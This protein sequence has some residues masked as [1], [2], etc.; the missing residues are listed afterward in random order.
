MSI[1]K[2]II[3]ATQQQVVNLGFPVM[4]PLSGRIKPLEEHPEVIFSTGALG[5]GL[6]LEISSHKI[7]APFDGIIEKVKM[8]GTEVY[9]K[10][11]NGLR[12]LVALNID[13]S[14]F[15]LPGLAIIKH[16]NQNVKASEAIVHF[17]LRKVP[18]P[19]IASVTILNYQKLGAIYYSHNQITAGEDVLFKVT[20]KKR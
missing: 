13:P 6:A 20:A 17:D 1:H 18:T 8:G 7:I 4:S 19:I 14:Y 9:F 12:L 2:Q 5:C 10:A 15:P 3:F 16:E 11:R